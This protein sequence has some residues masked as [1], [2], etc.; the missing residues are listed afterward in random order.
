MMKLCN[1]QTHQTVEPHEGKLYTVQGLWCYN[2]TAVQS[3]VK[4]LNQLLLPD[5]YLATVPCQIISAVLP[6]SSLVTHSTL[7]I[8]VLSDTVVL[9]YTVVL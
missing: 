9:R 7:V 4:A 8:E 5:C 6:H 3:A 1:N 2:C